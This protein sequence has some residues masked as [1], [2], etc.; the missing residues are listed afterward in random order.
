MD[1]SKQY[2]KMCDCEEIQGQRTGRP[3][4]NDFVHSVHHADSWLK[5][6]GWEEGSLWLPRQDQI[7]KMLL[8]FLNKLPDFTGISWMKPGAQLSYLASSFV[9]FMRWAS[10]KMIPLEKNTC[11]IEY[12]FDSFEQLW[13]A[14]YMH[15]KHSK[16]WNKTTWLQK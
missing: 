14:F 6:V 8:G 9:D 7:Q 2:I 12:F 16:V 10:E 11:R 13:L 1:E 15:K 3:N 4:Y 5:E